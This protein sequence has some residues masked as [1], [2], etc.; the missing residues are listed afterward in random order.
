MDSKSY[1][2]EYNFQRRVVTHLKKQGF[3]CITQPKSAFPDILAWRP[4]INGAG[5][6]FAINVQENLSGTVTNKTVLPFYVSFIECKVNKYLSKKEKEAAKLILKE[7][8][9]N[10]FLV[11]HR[12]GRK[13]LFQEITLNGEEA[14]V[15][16]LIPKE[17]PSYIGQ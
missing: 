11:A 10:T 13:L 4:F 5:D 17:L 16:T 15:T 7:G 12:E 9:C 8:R 14:V 3:N 1:R 6:V 2:I